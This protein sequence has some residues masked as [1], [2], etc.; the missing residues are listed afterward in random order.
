MSEKTEISLDLYQ[1]LQS[2]LSD[3]AFYQKRRAHQEC[4]PVVNQA[5]NTSAERIYTAAEKLRKLAPT[6]PDTED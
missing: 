2:L 3:Y 6:L 1:E 4:D 5:L